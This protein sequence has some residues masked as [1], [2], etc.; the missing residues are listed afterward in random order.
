MLSIKPKIAS[1]HILEDASPPTAISGHFDRYRKKQGWQSH[2][3]GSAIFVMI[4]KL[5]C[6]VRCD[7]L[8]TPQMRF[9]LPLSR[10]FQCD[11]FVF[12]FA[13]ICAIFDYFDCFEQL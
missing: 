8:L 9:L 13:I 3:R 4:I 1:T 10:F 11:F 6:H 7:T 12:A 5:R 2:R